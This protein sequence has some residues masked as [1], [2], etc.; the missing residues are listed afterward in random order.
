MAETTISGGSYGDSRPSMAP[1]IQSGNVRNFVRFI[2]RGTSIM[3]DGEVD[4]IRSAKS[5]Q[6]Q[7]CRMPQTAAASSLR[8]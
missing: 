8:P 4:C 2:E 6:Q 5:L 3:R 1:E 7:S